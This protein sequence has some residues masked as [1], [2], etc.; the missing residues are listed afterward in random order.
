MGQSPVRGFS[1]A[2]R[3][4]TVEEFV[5]KYYD[6][7]DDHSILINTVEKREVGG[8]YAFA[9]LL[10]NK[11]PVLAGVCVIEDVY[12]DENNPFGR[13]GMRL[14]IKKLGLESERVFADLEACRI[15]KRKRTALIT[16]MP[17]MVVP[18]NGD[19]RASV[20]GAP[21][22]TMTQ[23]MRR[24]LTQPLPMEGEAPKR[25]VTRPRLESVQIP[26][27]TPKATPSDLPDESEQPQPGRTSTRT[28][29][30]PVAVAK[31]E[32]VQINPR[33]KA[34]LKPVEKPR[35]QP[36]PAVPEPKPEGKKLDPAAFSKTRLESQ[37]GLKR[38][39]SQPKVETQPL[40][41]L[42]PGRLDPVDT[43]TVIEDKTVA[44][45]TVTGATKFEKPI[46][47]ESGA[48]ESGAPEPSAKPEPSFETTTGILEQNTLTEMIKKSKAPT[49]PTAV[50]VV[51]E[52]VPSVSDDV[53]ALWSRAFSMPAEVSESKPTNVI[54][55]VLKPTR[56]RAG[57]GHEETTLAP[58]DGTDV[59]RLD[60]VMPRREKSPTFD[61]P[62]QQKPR[63]DAAAALAAKPEREPE[64]Q[65]TP[66]SSFILPANPLT[67]L[68]DVAL[69]GLIDCRLFESKASPAL[70]GVPGFAVST[71]ANDEAPL[72][73][74]AR[75]SYAPDSL[76]TKSSEPA[77][78]APTLASRGSAAARSTPAGRAESIDEP[79]PL[80][81]PPVPARETKS[82]PAVVQLPDLPTPLVEP[83]PPAF[84]PSKP[85]RFSTVHNFA[86]KHARALAIIG[87]F[88]V[89]FSIVALFLVFRAPRVHA[90]IVAP[91]VTEPQ[92]GPSTTFA[93]EPMPKIGTTVGKGPC[94]IAVETDPANAMVYVQGWYA[95]RSPINVRGG[96]VS[97]RV[98]AAYPGLFPTSQKVTAVEGKDVPVTLT[99][100][101]PQHT[102]LVK[103]YPAGAE[104]KVNGRSYG[105]SP[106]YVRVPGN[107]PTDI[108]ISR[109]GY[110][111]LT[112]NVT[113]TQRV[114]GR[115]WLE[116]K[117]KK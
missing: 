91:S 32:K 43:K 36:M 69:A 47:P 31:I 95:G 14:A 33:Q 57:S 85:R 44:E 40:T 22:R 114:G 98:T 37:P 92:P 26:V 24:L 113:S 75:G 10:A 12:T 115:I 48:P 29:F 3:C 70:F 65:R 49:P 58:A 99:L 84:V 66:G 19:V 117:A 103:T 35:T 108:E 88:T 111:T 63:P 107:T 73:P 89:G 21:R 25:T 42:D 112:H 94:I 82:Q 86:R 90:P 83:P 1:V 81:E 56:P 15:S 41:K 74:L 18:T 62:T 20:D 110:E 53:D 106:T 28:D 51:K 55:P 97:K 17:V 116:L 109:A 2:T 105:L 39:A 104:V 13:A 79:A 7:S 76:E 4:Q 77:P 93:L 11:Q 23:P 101:R 72:A 27:R 78:R 54:E 61:V 8:E 50:P 38:A 5:Q 59:K 80:P 68:T 34:E 71:V 87:A 30:A 100:G 67:D 6:R 9:I 64:E 102:I 16:P 52:A 96:C 46:A 60:E 45:V